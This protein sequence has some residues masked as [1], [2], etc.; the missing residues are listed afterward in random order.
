V[1]K[2]ISDRKEL[3]K[4]FGSY[5]QSDIGSRKTVLRLLK[6][7]VASADQPIHQIQF[8]A[9]L[10]ASYVTATSEQS[11][12]LADEFLGAGDDE[13][14]RKR[15]RK[16]KRRDS[17]PPRLIDA[18]GMGKQMALQLVTQGIRGIDIYYPRMLT[19]GASFI[20]PPRYYTLADRRGRKHRAYRMVVGFS[21][22]NGFSSEFYGLQGTTWRKPPILSGPSEERKVGDRNVRV[23]YDG[24][25][26]RLIAWRTKRAVYW[27]SNSLLQSLT[28]K[29]MLAIVRSTK[30]L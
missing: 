30:P 22:V 4:I 2:I 7:V 12:R 9:S 21:R 28:L 10:G 20:A 1:R 25:R 14:A 24:E 11:H 23:Y 17:R 15:K 3:I 29:Q 18:S 16:R 13:P 6:L 5:T 19:P 27:V 26:V 8:T